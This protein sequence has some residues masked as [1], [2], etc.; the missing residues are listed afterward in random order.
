MRRLSRLMLFAVPVFLGIASSASAAAFTVND[1]YPITPTHYAY[2][3]AG[4]NLLHGPGSETVNFSV[5]KNFPLRERMK[6]QFRFESFALFN[7]T[8]FGMPDTGVYSGTF[9]VISGEVGQ[10][11]SR[12]MQFALR[13]EF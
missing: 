1:L 11:P 2:G 6:L 9:G 4:R 12:V 7:H 5:F 13:F 8:N 3:D 10:E